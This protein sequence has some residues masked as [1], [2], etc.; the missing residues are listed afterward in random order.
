MGTFAE[1]LPLALHQPCPPGF[2]QSQPMM[3][4]VSGLWLM[5]VP[6][7]CKG[8]RTWARLCLLSHL[9]PHLGLLSS[10]K[11]PLPQGRIAPLHTL[12]SPSSLSCSCLLVPPLPGSHLSCCLLCSF[13]CAWNTV[14]HA[15]PGRVILDP[16]C[17][18]VLWVFGL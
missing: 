1:G 9:G 12:S 18:R 16:A 13:L 17:L 7:H 15:R 14:S 2:L 10:T 6:E 8:T 5:L 11:S 3:K 4:W